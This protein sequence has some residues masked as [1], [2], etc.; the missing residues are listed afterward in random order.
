MKKSDS[1][2]TIKHDGTVR[3][4][5]D[6][7]VFVSIKSSS[8][9]SGCHA[10]G[11]CGISGA[12]DKII[13]VK[14]SYDVSPGDRVTVVLEES[15]GYKAV[16]LSYVLPLVL[17]IAALVAFNSLSVNELIAGLISILMLV[18]YFLIL[19]I[20]RSKINRSF[21]FTLKT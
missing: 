10:E 17:V 19:Y 18:P 21:T 9:C 1:H 2:D 16:V 20:F 3:K 11:I 14:G 13:D 4:V 15:A 8:A 6:N 12:E 7:C 5:E